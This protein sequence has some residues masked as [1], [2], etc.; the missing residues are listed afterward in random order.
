MKI[1]DLILPA[2]R[3]RKSTHQK[4]FLGDLFDAGLLKLPEQQK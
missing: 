3:A 2:V 4:K 1:N